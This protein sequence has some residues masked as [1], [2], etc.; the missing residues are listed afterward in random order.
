MPALVR[1]SSRRGSSVR[2]RSA[3]D[4]MEVKLVRSRGQTEMA[5]WGAQLAP[6]RTASL[7]VWPLEAVLSFQKFDSGA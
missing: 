6:R 2:T 3:K 4:S 1:K 7:A 5:V